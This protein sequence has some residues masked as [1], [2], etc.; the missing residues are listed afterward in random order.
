VVIQY[1][2]LRAAIMPNCP[3]YGFQWPEHSA[4]LQF[5]GGGECGLDIVCNARCAME[6]AHTP[7]DYFSCEVVRRQRHVLEAGR[8][9][10]SF[11]PPAGPTYCL[12]DW[13]IRSPKDVRTR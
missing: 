3:F 1:A 11:R 8:L 4:T 9:L 5:K 12:E 13:Q 10:I 6:I 2:A 7:I